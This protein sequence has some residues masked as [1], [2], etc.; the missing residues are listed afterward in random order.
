M[1]AELIDGEL[2]AT[3][4]PAT[5]HARVTSVLAVDLGAPFDRPPGDP[6]GPGGWWLLFEPELH[7]ARDVIVPDYAGWRRARLPILPDVAAL[8]LAPDWAC[9]VLSPTT[10]AIDRGRKMRVYPR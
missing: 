10:A 8:E 1:V 6:D 9:E 7:L 4:R 5:P 2:I 3:P